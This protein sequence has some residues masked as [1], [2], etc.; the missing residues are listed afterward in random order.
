VL[1]LGFWGN[2]KKAS[3]ADMTMLQGIII[4]QDKSQQV[5]LVNLNRLVPILHDSDGTVVIRNHACAHKSPL[6]T[7]ATA[8]GDLYVDTVGPHARIEIHHGIHA[9]LRAVNRE[10]SLFLNDGCTAWLFGDNIETMRM[11]NGNQKIRP[12]TTLNGGVTE[13]LGG[14]ID[15]LST[16]H[17]PKDGALFQTVNSTLWANAAGEIRSK[18]GVIGSWPIYCSS[19]QDGRTQLLKDSDVTVIENAPDSCS[20][21]CVL[22]AYFTSPQVHSSS[23]Q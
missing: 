19:T 1:Q 3:P 6:L 23:A 10:K 12:I 8:T 18:D 16:H 2:V 14:C 11:H 13:Y 9:W 5:I 7:T 15:V 22:P 21:C 20:R 17:N 4:K